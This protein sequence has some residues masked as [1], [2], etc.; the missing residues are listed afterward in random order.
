MTVRSIARGVVVAAIAI[1]GLTLAAGPSI[2]SATVAA[3]SACKTDSGGDV[4]WTDPC[5]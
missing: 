3:P 4:E 2:A 1:A 5:G